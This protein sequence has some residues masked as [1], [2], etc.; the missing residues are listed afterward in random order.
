MA[1]RIL[2]V[3]DHKVF[4]EG[5]RL[6]VAEEED[7]ELVGESS[8]GQEAV[9]LAE[10]LNPDVILMDVSMPGLNGVEAARRITERNGSVKVLA[11]SGYWSERFVMEM[12]KAGV[13]GYVVKD[14]STL[15]LASAIRVVMAGERYLSPKAAKVL[16]ENYMR[17]GEGG[18]E[19]SLLE[20]EKHRYTLRLQ[21]D[22]RYRFLIFDTYIFYLDSR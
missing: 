19:A 8:N 6:L 22:L 7:M 11:L 14:C 4:R 12:L 3:D 10:S 16:I 20:Q 5:L 21:L 2:V 13:C 18:S 9:E 15:E 17:S 1:I